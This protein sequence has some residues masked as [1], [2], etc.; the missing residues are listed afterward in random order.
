[1]AYPSSIRRAVSPD[2]DLDR[3]PAHPCVPITAGTGV[4]AEAPSGSMR[5]A[6]MGV[7]SEDSMTMSS[8]MVWPAPA[9]AGP[10]A[11]R[12]AGAAM[13]S[14]SSRT[15]RRIRLRFDGGRALSFIPYRGKRR[16]IV[17][18]PFA[19]AVHIGAHPPLGLFVQAP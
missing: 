4:E 3:L 10:V 11:G 19:A 7:P 5:V 16:S 14:A 1:M 6:T 12:E 18:F 8:S 2:G 17:F 13:H 9:A 15:R